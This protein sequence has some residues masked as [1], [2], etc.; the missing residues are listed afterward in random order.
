MTRIC[1]NVVCL[2]LMVSLGL[3]F[4]CSD[5]AGTGPVDAGGADTAVGDDAGPV[6]IRA[7]SMGPIVIPPGV[8][9]TECV[10]LPLDNQQPAMI[11]SIRTEL[12][13]GSHHMIITRASGS[14]EPNP[15]PCNAFGVAGDTLFIAEKPEADLRYPAGAG[16]RVEAQ[17]LI[18]IEIHYINVSDAEIELT[19]TVEFELAPV[20]SGLREVALLFTGDLALTLPPMTPTTVHSFHGVPSGAEIFGLTSHTHQYGTYAAIRRASSPGDMSGELLHEALVWSEP[21]LDTFDPPL[22]LE[23]NEGLMLTCEYF[24]TTDQTVNFG[25]SAYDEMC[26]LWAHYVVP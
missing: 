7:V 20:D 22:V 3:L 23:A 17:A 10:K 1:S 14:P 6:G 13:T 2:A 18:G 12:G 15:R 24:N 26:F 25:T 5:D 19:G 11:R 8:E 16:L 9:R 4:S 21:P